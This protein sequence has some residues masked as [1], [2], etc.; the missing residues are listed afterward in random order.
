MGAIDFLFST[1][2]QTAPG[3]HLDS[4]AMGNKFLSR[5]IKRPGSGFDRP[6][7][8]TT[9][10]KLYFYFPVCLTGMLRGN[11]YLCS[12]CNVQIILHLLLL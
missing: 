6:P 5:G 7:P 11:F 9:K 10:V 1:P 12:F 3:A 4:S 8:S 2:V